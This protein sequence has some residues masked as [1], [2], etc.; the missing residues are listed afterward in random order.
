MKVD[1]V[2]KHEAQEGEWLQPYLFIDLLRVKFKQPCNEF[3]F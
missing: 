1:V 3:F 2:A